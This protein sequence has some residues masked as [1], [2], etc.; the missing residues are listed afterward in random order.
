MI[1]TV[2]FIYQTARPVRGLQCSH[3]R[4][5]VRINSLIAYLCVK[6][7]SCFSSVR[8]YIRFI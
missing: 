8:S 3:V 4:L 5:A 7:L 6:L 1:I 2:G